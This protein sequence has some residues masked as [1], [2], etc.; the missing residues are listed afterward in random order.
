MIG[1]LA[2]MGASHSFIRKIFL[3]QASFI[4]W[5]GIGIGSFLGIG[6]ALL[7]QKFNFIQLDESAYFIK[8]LPIHINWMQVLLVIVSTAIISYISFLIPTLWIKKIAPAKAIK[9]D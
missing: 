4:C 8:Y 7:Q 9:F 6:L 1:T 5:M 3:Y 2:S